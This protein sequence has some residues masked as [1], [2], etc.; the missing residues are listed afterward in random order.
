METSTDNT[1]PLHRVERLE[2]RDLTQQD[3][4]R[5]NSLF[6]KDMKNMIY[7]SFSVRVFRK[8]TGGP[9]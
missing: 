5:L 3:F 7:E 4:D 1:L 9:E 6:G 8:V 2:L